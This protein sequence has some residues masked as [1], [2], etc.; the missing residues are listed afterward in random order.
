MMV[1]SDEECC[2][3]VDVSDARRKT[4]SMTIVELIVRRVVYC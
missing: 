1:T 3:R 2:V 4:L